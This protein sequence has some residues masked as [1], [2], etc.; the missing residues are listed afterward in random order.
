[1]DFVEQV[2]EFNQ[3]IL[4]IEQREL[5]ALPNSEH[6]ISHHCLH[7]EIMEY[8][9]ARNRGDIIGQVDA[10]IDLLYFGV[11]IVYKMGLSV[12]QI[13]AVCTAV[14]EANMTKQR[15]TNAKRAYEGAADATKPLDWVSPEK[16]IEAILFESQ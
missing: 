9:D 14:H 6:F 2:V 1:M 11:G 12:E 10:I 4:G 3:K 13:R 8:V 5:G 16:R 7:E 15:G